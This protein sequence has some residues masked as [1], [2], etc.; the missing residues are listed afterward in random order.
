M[1][2]DVKQ[3]GNDNE[4]TQSFFTRVAPNQ[5]A[6]RCQIRTDKYASRTGQKAELS[7]SENED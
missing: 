2:S 5:A 6:P 3:E 7:H 1:A 4:W